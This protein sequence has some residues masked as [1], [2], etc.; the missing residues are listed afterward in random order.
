MNPA[1]IQRRVTRSL[2]LVASAPDLLLLRFLNELIYLRD[3]EGLLLVPL[4]L[5]VELNGGARLEAQLCGEL[6]DPLR[7]DPA[8]DV[9]AATAHRLQVL[10]TRDGWKAQVTL[11]V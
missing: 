11:D 7:H 1:G 10:P 9:K 8:D 4:R 5:H 3:A 2:S 6:L